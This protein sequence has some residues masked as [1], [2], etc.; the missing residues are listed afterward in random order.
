MLQTINDRLKGIVGGIIVF[1]LSITFASWGI[2]EY[3]TSSKE[4]HAAS[5][6]GADISVREY[7][8]AVS[9]QRQR[10]QAAFGD[11]MPT[12]AA[13]EHKLKEQ[14]LDQ[15]VLQRVMS[16]AVE[17]KNYRIP[18]NILVEKIQAIEAFQKDGK[19]ATATF[20]QIIGSQG[21]TIR[22][23]EQLYRRDLM[24]QQMQTGITKSVVL[25]DKALQS[26]EQLQNQVRDISYVAFDSAK[27]MSAI[28]P[29]DDEVQK[30][31]AEHQDSYQHPEQASIAY[32][33]LT[34]DNLKAVTKT[35]EE[36][37]RRQYDEYVAGLSS[38]D[39]RKAKHILI[40]VD[41]GA[42]AQD[43][44]ESKKKIE[45][46]L[47][48]LKLGK[49]FS[50]LAKQYSDDTVSAK[51]GG[52]LGWVSKG[53]TDSAF[54][55]ALFSLNKKGDTSSIVETGF[56]YHII[57]LDDM[58]SAKADSFE[59][60]KAELVKAAQ[61]QEIDNLF[62]DRS[63]QLATLAYENDQTLQPAADAL[64]LKI[65]NTGM[66]TRTGGQGVAANEAVRKAVFSDAVLK[67]GRN[68]E[69]IELSKN[70]ILVLRINE[71]QPSRPMAL[72]E[73]KPF[74]EMALKAE[75]ARQTVMATGL[76]A[77]ADA[78]AGK[79]LDEIA[80]A[81]HGEIKQLGVVKRD[82]SGVDTRIVQ[83]AFRFNKPVA[84]QLSYDT[85]ETQNGIALIAV[86]SVSSKQ[87]ASKPETIQAA[88]S[89]LEG[90]LAQQEIEAV[91]NYLKSKSDITLGKDLL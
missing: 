52:D 19:F 58:K 12:D 60:K 1:F 66:F 4:Q 67:E 50:D 88:A 13:F 15:L 87:D 31:F 79:S 91:L 14:V 65:Q 20:Q 70:D 89:L 21:M 86:A 22:D 53:M 55:Q 27:I 30:Y 43:K 32:I 47:A 54:E 59:S 25:G 76:Q 82:Q 68:S 56:G 51:Q 5:V 90:D 63:E 33:E 2:Q 57:Q 81:Y 38:A 24:A 41:A 40:K 34:A 80:K 62:Y 61:Q 17:A 9:K 73:V 35:D 7:E 44:A 72:E 23:F 11:K 26:Y 84:Q 3:L 39:E 85:V 6:N 64:G 74:V 75:K 45:Q 71:H 46:I 28:I 42:T 83:A 29:T 10:Y 77:L 37:L 8:D 18:D 48:Q 69:V 49:S 36:Q 16:Q 78:K